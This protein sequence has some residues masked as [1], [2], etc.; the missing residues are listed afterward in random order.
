VRLCEESQYLFGNR[1][2]S[3]PTRLVVVVVVVVASSIFVQ[4]L[5]GVMV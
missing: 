3:N 1:G 5:V 2:G 4:V